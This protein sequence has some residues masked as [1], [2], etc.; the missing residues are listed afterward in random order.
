MLEQRIENLANHV[1]KLTVAI[2]KLTAV[3]TA[4]HVPASALKTTLKT[5]TKPVAKDP[6]KVTVEAVKHALI[7]LSHAKGRDV[8]VS[9]LNR[10]NNA[11][12]IGDLTEDQYANVI[13]AAQTC[14]EAV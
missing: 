11:N 14:M 5:T 4:G 13:E 9:V 2:D 12:K 10:F 6:K 1:A 3:L 8:A 7:Q